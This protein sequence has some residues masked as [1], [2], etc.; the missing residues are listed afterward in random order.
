MDIN[1]CESFGGSV[2][3]GAQ[4]GSE[5]CCETNN[6]GGAYITCSNCPTYDDCLVCGNSNGDMDCNG[7]C[8]ETAAPCDTDGVCCGGLTGSVCDACGI[9]G[10][11]ESSC[12]GC[13]DINACESF[14]G[15]VVSGAQCGSE[16]CCETNNSG[17]AYITCSNCPTYDD[18]LVC[19]NSNGDM[20]CNG[21]CFETA[22]PCDTDGVCCG[23]LTGSVCDACGIC[24]GDESSCTGCMD[25]NACDYDASA[26]LDGD[27]NYT[28]C[29]NDGQGTTEGTGSCV[30]TNWDV[31]AAYG[32]CNYIYTD[33]SEQ[34]DSCDTC[35]GAFYEG[36][37]WCG[38]SEGDSSC[39]DCEGVANGG[40]Y[41]DCAGT[42]SD[43]STI[44]DGTNSNGGTLDSDGND[45]AGV[46]GGDAFLD[47]CGECSGGGSG[48]EADINQDCNLNY[49]CL[50]DGSDCEVNVDDCGVCG[51]WLPDAYSIYKDCHG[52]CAPG[53]R[54]G[55]C[56]PNPYYEEGGLCYQYAST[57]ICPNGCPGVWPTSGPYS[58]VSHGAP[59]S[60]HPLGQIA[61]D[62]Y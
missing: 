17:G 29:C 24:G 35:G 36:S 62:A 43:E 39:C 9:C 16:N 52:D 4:C 58:D 12:T 38:G 20:D 25:I 54:D 30:C 1:A 11:D 2:V 15:S 41:L 55:S 13:M 57:A 28:E 3:S 45:C 10:G 27:C 19:G 42:C 26:T 32:Y 21:D 23:G 40:A 50:D 14:G 31:P 60:G 5:N 44:I 61:V 59:G 6:S 47:I 7:D 34:Y 56:V 22:A 18:C 37:D 33:C 8:F 53:S 48:H 51:E 49:T 46:C